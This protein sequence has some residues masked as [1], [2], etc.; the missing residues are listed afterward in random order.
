M[1]VNQTRYT[2]EDFPDG[3]MKAAANYCRNPNRD[4]KG[5][6]CYLDTSDIYRYCNAP[7]CGNVS[8]NGR[9]CKLSV[10]GTDYTGNISHT[11][12]GL[13]CQAWYEQT[14]NIHSIGIYDYQ[15]PDNDIYAAAN[16]CR[17]PNEDNLGPWCYTIQKGV[18]EY[19]SIPFCYG[20]CNNDKSPFCT[21]TTANPI[22]CKSTRRG[23]DYAGNISVT[24]QGYQ[25]QAWHRQTPNIHYKGIFDHEFP[26]SDIYIDY[27][28][29]LNIDHYSYVNI[30]HYSYLNVEH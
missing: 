27:Y 21:N 24:I 20:Y 6:W 19:C 2:D 1:N 3:S 29:Y 23:S 22:N 12:H 26:E 14:P 7:Y 16:Y 18:A 10:K 15:F 4:I 13:Q 8:H 28:S 11:I 25:C 9:E 5:I 17:N 30:D